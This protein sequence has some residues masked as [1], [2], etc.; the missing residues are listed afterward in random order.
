[1]AEGIRVNDAALE[2]SPAGVQALVN[3]EGADITLTRLDL[4]ISADSLNTLLSGLA[5]EGQ[6]APSAELADGR[7]R[8]TTQKDGKSVG[9]EVRVASFRL[10]I[11]ADGLR[12][13][14]E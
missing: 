14:S 10:Q 5:T 3:C 2:I 7:V 1:M 8:V 13:V 12:L 9:L 4:S 11:G 6:P